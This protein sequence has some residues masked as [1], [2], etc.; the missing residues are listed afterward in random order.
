MNKKVAIFAFNVEAMCFAHALLNA[1]DM[2]KKGYDIKLVI[3]GTATKQIKDLSD[4][5]KPFA[6]LYKEIKEDKLIDCVCQAC[7]TA[8]GSLDSAKEQHLP[9]CNEMSGHPSIS[10]YGDEGYDVIVF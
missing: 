8:T 5:G 3:E 2:K 9:I 7:S 1:K 10:R 6:N 4:Q